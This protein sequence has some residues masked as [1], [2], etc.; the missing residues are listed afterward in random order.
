MLSTPMRGGLW[1]AFTIHVLTMRLAPV[2]VVGRIH[3][4]S[5]MSRGRSSGGASAIGFWAPQTT[6]VSS[7]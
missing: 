4:A 7:W 1:P 5:D 3:S 6:T 2:V